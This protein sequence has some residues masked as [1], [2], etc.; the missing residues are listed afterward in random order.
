MK[1]ISKDI[2]ESWRK[3]GT[4][5]E[6]LWILLIDNSLIM[7]SRVKL[8]LKMGRYHSISQW[9]IEHNT[10]MVTEL[11]RKKKI[12]SF[13]E[14]RS[15]PHNTLGFPQFF[16]FPELPYKP[17]NYLSAHHSDYFPPLFPSSGINSNS[18]PNFFQLLTR[19]F[20]NILPSSTFL[21]WACST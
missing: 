11:K 7:N 3:P 15:L 8:Q 13:W 9:N 20:F 10:K 4:G 16:D 6:I 17:R 18:I 14:V 2:V 5:I 1:D 19:H 21:C 12:A